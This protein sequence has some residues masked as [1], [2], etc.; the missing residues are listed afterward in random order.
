MTALRYPAK[1]KVIVRV[2][3]PHLLINQPL[4]SYN[5]NVHLNLKYPQVGLL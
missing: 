3:L 5:L 2:T 4:T 1:D